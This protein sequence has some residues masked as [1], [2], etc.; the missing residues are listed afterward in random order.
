MF[1]LRNE[2]G[3]RSGKLNASTAYQADIDDKNEGYGSD[4]PTRDYSV[5]GGKLV[6]SEIKLLEASA[7]KEPRQAASRNGVGIVRLEQHRAKRGAQRQRNEARD[8]RGCRDRYCELAEEV[9]GNPRKKGG[10]HE[11]RAQGQ[12]DRDE[13]SPNLVHRPMGGLCWGYPRPDDALDGLDDDDSVVNYDPD[14]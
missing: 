5:Q 3:G 2:S 9:S 1:L 8:Y 4:E 12:C 7:K 11:N 6:E 10:G 13:C 14:C